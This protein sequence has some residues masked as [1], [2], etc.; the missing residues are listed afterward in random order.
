[1][2]D[3]VRVGV[4]GT[5]W[6]VDMMY[7][8]SLN[9][10]P[11]AEVV[12]VCGRNAERAGAI[13][14]KFGGARVFADYRE[15]IARGRPRC[16]GH[17][18]PRR[19]PPRDGHRRGRCRPACPL[20]EAARQHARR[21]GR[22]AAAGR[23][24]GR[25]R[26]WCSSPGAGSRTG[27]TSSTSSTPVISAAASGRASPSSRG[28]RSSKGYKWRFDGRRGDRRRRRS[29]LAHDRHGALVPRRR[30][31]GQRRPSRC[32]PT[33]RRRPI[34]RRFRSTTRASSRS[35]CGTARRC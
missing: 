18:R 26:T 9:S 32:S 23:G 2:A 31:H 13:A 11:G 27:A 4:I 5:S 8:P 33:S 3:K 25:R 7:V 12:A 35:A 10:H 34:R 24:C 15:M 21:R 19:C 14:A 20:R 30:R 22:D 28:S 17:R 1:M 29:R 16:G 6:W